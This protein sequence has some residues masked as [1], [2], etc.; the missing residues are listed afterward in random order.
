MNF[1][2][3]I[4]YATTS[5]TAMIALSDTGNHATTSGWNN[6]DKS[7]A[8]SGTYTMSLLN[9]TGGAS[10][11]SIMASA[12]VPG[13]GFETVGGSFSDADFPNDIINLQW[14]NPTFTLNITGLNPSK[15]YTIK[16]VHWDNS[17]GTITT[18]ITVNATIQTATSD[19]STLG[20]LT[21]SGVSP[22][23]TGLI[24]IKFD[25]GTVFPAWNGLIITG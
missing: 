5:Q 25:N 19:N 17:S 16:T 2:Y 6:Y 22:D 1:P 14:Y 18:K 4:S 8:A 21:F 10:G 13:I 11:W 23:G 20:K 3:Q 24:T 12:I 15:T 7:L 9:S